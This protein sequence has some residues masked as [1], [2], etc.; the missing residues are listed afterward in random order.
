MY[1]IRAIF[2]GLCVSLFFQ[3]HSSAQNS[4]K[5]AQSKI[6]PLDYRDF[7]RICTLTSTGIDAHYRL[8]KE[9]FNSQAKTAGAT[10]N[11]QV[12]YI[13]RPSWPEEAITAFEYAVNIWESHITSDVPIRI[14][15]NWTGLGEFTLGSAGPSQIIQ[16]VQA[17]PVAWYAIA[18]ASAITGVDYVAQSEGSGNEIEH[19]II[20]NMNSEWDSWYYGTDAQTPDGLIDFVTV[21]LHELGHGLGFTGSVRVPEGTTAQ[22]GY[23]VPLRPI[24]YDVFVTDGTGVSILNE[25][26]YPNPSGQLYSAVTGQSNG[27]RFDGLYS[28]SSN[29]GGIVPLYA[30]FN[31]RGGSS[32]SHLDL[33]T[34]TN[35]VNA[36]MRPQIGRAFA[37]HSPGPVTCG[38]FRDMGWPLA[39]DCLNLLDSDSRLVLNNM[40][41][42]RIDF[43][44]INVGE[45][46]EQTIVV[47]NDAGVQDP[48]VGRVRT[49]AGNLFTSEIEDEIFTLDPGESLEIPVQFQPALEGK[50]TGELEIAYNASEG[51]NPV[52][53]SLGGEALPENEVFVLDQNY[54]NPFNA[55]TTI[56]YALAQTADVRLDVFDALGKHVQT[57]VDTRQP[58]G[59][60]NQ[61]FQAN[62]VSS[63]IFIYRLIVDGRSKT[64]KLILVK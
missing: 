12:E 23:G 57:L 62:N 38:I 4:Q 53:V 1:F 18:Q 47:S 42:N 5:Y 9:Q 33:D 32:Y 17:D 26:V 34:F 59:R 45:T 22:W 54:P 19:D 43:G 56:P 11:I 20:V 46:I 14:G 21:V 37:I 36:L 24:V 13:D 31:W 51:Q 15:A 49:T 39:E 61:P 10:A 27:L 8:P 3:V 60:Y 2:A 63:G 7:E 58:S 35:T 6:I 41:I 30:P 25:S 44:V 64:G 28:V 50:F 29:N 16:I 48:L 55:T 52:V 40:N